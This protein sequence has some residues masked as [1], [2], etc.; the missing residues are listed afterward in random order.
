MLWL[1][2]GVVGG[3]ALMAKFL[4]IVLCG[5]VCEAYWFHQGVMYEIDT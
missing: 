3:S 5:R 2:A 4:D 1:L